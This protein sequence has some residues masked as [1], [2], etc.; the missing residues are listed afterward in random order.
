MATRVAREFKMAKVISK[1]KDAF[2]NFE[3]MDTFEAGIQ[4][5][6]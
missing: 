3:I 5:Q 6:G 4:L 2:F 1:N